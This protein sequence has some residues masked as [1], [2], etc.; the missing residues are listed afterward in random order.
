MWT[1]RVLGELEL[2]QDGEHVAAPTGV[3]AETLVLIA[4]SGTGGILSKALEDALSESGRRVDRGTLQRRVADLRQGTGTLMPRMGKAKRY[5]LDPAE[6]DAVDALDFVVGV[7][8]LAE[9]PDLAQL[10]RLMG[11]W[12]GNPLT[13]VK[14]R[15]RRWWKPVI[16][17]RQTLVDVLGRLNSTQ[18]ALLTRLAGF[19]ELFPDDIALQRVNGG[20]SG[21]PRLLVVE[22][23]IMD[24][25]VRLL[26]DEF[27]LLPVTSYE[28]WREICDNGSLDTVQGALID[29]HLDVTRPGDSVGTTK[30]AE[31]LRRNT[32]IPAILMSV[33]VD[34][35]TNKVLDLCLKYRLLDVIRKHENGTLNGAELIEAARSLVDPSPKGRRQ[36]MERWVA[37]VAYHVEA[38]HAFS[39]R[40]GKNRL[41]KCQE[42]RDHILTLLQRGDLESAEQAMASFRSS[43]PP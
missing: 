13:E 12:R 20:P 14:D 10:D 3:K 19:A 36:R 29:R 40:L 21:L 39:P 24:E 22:D 30:I 4:L 6:V 38:D 11:L 33:D 7:G 28:G 1:V 5:L 34:H 25:L 18:R 35:S 8:A 43:W 37:S 23:Q 42:E 32:S 17:A 27:D 9:A 15:A 41:L 31:Y 26:D 16:D 2:L